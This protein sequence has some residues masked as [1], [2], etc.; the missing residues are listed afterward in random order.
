MTVFTES[1]LRSSQREFV[2]HV[3]LGIS[4][5]SETVYRAIL[6]SPR[7][8]LSELSECLSYDV[9]RVAEVV[10]GLRQEGLV[11]D[12]ADE[13]GAVRAVEPCLAL[14]ALAARRLCA[15]RGIE[16]VP[17]PEAVE[18]LINLREQRRSARE[19]EMAGLDEL[20]AVVERLVSHAGREVVM[21][22]PESEQ[23]P[24]EFSRLIPEWASRRGLTVRNVWRADAIRSA[25]RRAHS[26]WLGSQGFE[27]RVVRSV[28]LRA[29][30][31]DDAV[32]VVGDDEEVR[33]LRGARQVAEVRRIAAELWNSATPVRSDGTS[34]GGA[35][36]AGSRHATVLR[37]LAEGLTD[38][39]IARRT[40]VSVRT[41]RNDVASAMSRLDSRSRF[42][43]GVR[44][45]RLG[46]F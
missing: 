1:P 29:V 21:L 30:L 12:S 24:Y 19:F 43:A 3:P 37:L 8:R 2:D 10:E 7:S 40:G 41:V 31:V 14:R 18:G 38:D 27:V 5:S 17:R 45:A 15:T 9:E 22:V 11:A 20:A 13:P 34:D 23:T 42:Q 35:G 46:L 26:A 6:G 28:P 39:G 25:S 36:V 44:A 16:P 33:V 32:A 4:R